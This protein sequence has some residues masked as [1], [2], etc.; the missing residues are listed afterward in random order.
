MWNA[1]RIF[2]RHVCFHFRDQA[3]ELSVHNDRDHL[4]I[5]TS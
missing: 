1:R 2:K 5:Y 4:P 3:V